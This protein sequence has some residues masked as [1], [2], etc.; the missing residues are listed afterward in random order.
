M[1]SDVTNQLEKQTEI[2]RWIYGLLSDLDWVSARCLFV[3][4]GS[5][6]FTSKR[7]LN[8]AGQ[9]LKI[10]L[11]RD[12]HHITDLQ[13]L[14]ADPERGSWLSAELD[15][16]RDGGFR[17]SYNYDR[18]VHHGADPFTPPHGP[19]YFPS[20][21]AWR[22]EFRRFPRSPEFLPDWARALLARDAAAE[23]GAVN[24]GL[25]ERA[26]AA[27]VVVPA[28]LAAVVALPGWAGVWARVGEVTVERLGEGFNLDRLVDYLGEDRAFDGFCQ[29]VYGFVARPLFGGMVPSGPA[30]AGLG[31]EL[32]VAGRLDL[33]AS[34]EERGAV[35]LEVLSEL[36]DAQVRQRLSVG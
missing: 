2:A 22:E 11:L 3:R 35:V 7:C 27:R 29:E 23:R 36:V 18:R 5:Q 30:G 24:R 17:F 10:P 13:V 19:P 6:S 21:D 14:M 32:V 28:G 12:T 1:T 25:L 33:G 31:D 9:S 34:A 16:A 26:V 8:A 15:L 4:A 20:D